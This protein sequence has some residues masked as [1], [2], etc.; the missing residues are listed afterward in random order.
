MLRVHSIS[1]ISEISWMEKWWIGSLGG[2]SYIWKHLPMH[3]T[4]P[5]ICTSLPWLLINPWDIILI[6]TAGPKLLYQITPYHTKQTRWN[7][8]GIAAPDTT[9]VFTEDM[10]RSAPDSD[11]KALPSPLAIVTIVTRMAQD[12]I[13]L[14]YLRLV[15]LTPQWAACV[16]S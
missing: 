15:L 4:G 11:S 7:Y 9:Y 5:K 8:T 16:A 6:S 1:K 10:G 12:L 2:G 13:K 3:G 14:I